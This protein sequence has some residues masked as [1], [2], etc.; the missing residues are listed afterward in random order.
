MARLTIFLLLSLF[1]GKVSSFLVDYVNELD[2]PMDFSC[3]GNTSLHQLA[4]S[5]DNRAEDRKWSFGCLPS[6]NEVMNCVWSGYVNDFDGPVLYECPGDDF[7]NGIRSVHDNGKED[8]RW[9]FQCCSLRGHVRDKCHFTGYVNQYDG[10]LSYT[11]PDD[12]LIHGTNS[13]HD[14]GPEDRIFAFEVCHF[15]EGGM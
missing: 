6:R 8:R 5:H 14:N 2:G 1:G 13:I 3:G 10:P 7:I 11:V 15:V 9:S 4:S 12:Q